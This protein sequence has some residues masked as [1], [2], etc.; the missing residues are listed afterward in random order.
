V[1]VLPA[2]DDDV[3]GVTP[4]LAPSCAPSAADDERRAAR[5]QLVLP[6]AERLRRIA[7]R[8]LTCADEV[9]DVV[10]EALLRAAT[11]ERLEE[12]YVGQ[13]L[14]SVT[15]RLCADVQR[16]RV[17]QLKVGVRDAV[18]TVDVEDP[19]EA[20]LDHDEAQ[21][22]YTECLKLPSRECEVVLA[23]ASGLSVREAAGALGVG[24]KSAEAALTKAR[25][26]MRRVVQ[27]TG[28]SVAAFVRRTRHLTA[29]AVVGTSLSAL[30]VGGALLPLAAHHDHAATSGAPAAG[31]A[32][33]AKRQATRAVAIR[34]AVRT[35]PASRTAAAA[36]AA[37][38]RHKPAQ[39]V[40]AVPRVGDPSLVGTSKPLTVEKKHHD[41]SM[42][43]TLA[44]CLAKGIQLSGG[45][46]LCDS[47]DT[48]VQLPRR[49]VGS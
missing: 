43:E 7:A 6:H 40:A 12:A 27:S 19:H 5:W 39:P 3:D 29:P 32:R 14:T 21:W 34:A 33:P 11:F 23:R 41:E 37:T 17:R 10:Q 8:R 1:T 26:R 30:M 38:A 45:Q 24:V 13:F 35:G 25:H 48:R 49:V 9:D 15:V 47:G 42:E 44:E 2:F 4:C 36:P 31:A 18:R 16:E 20:L 22:L 28:A 46:L